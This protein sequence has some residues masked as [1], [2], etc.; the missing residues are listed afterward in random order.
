VHWGFIV[1]LLGVHYI[2]QFVSVGVPDSSF[3]AFGVGF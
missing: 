1:I 3:R 2:C